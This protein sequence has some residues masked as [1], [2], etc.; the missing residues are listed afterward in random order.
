MTARGTR[1]ET[2]YSGF[3]GCRSCSSDGIGG[4]GAAA[5]CTS[6]RWFVSL[7]PATVPGGGARA[8]WAPVGTRGDVWLLAGAER[9]GTGCV[10]GNK[11]VAQPRRESAWLGGR[12]GEYGMAAFGRCLAIVQYG[13]LL[14]S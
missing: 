13:S 8:E 4:L 12:V 6:I 3:F 11:V 1:S 2:K 14:A 7:M 5:A 10:K 9:G